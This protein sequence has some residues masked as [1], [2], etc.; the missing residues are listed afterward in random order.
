MVQT[1]FN[2]KFKINIKRHKLKIWRLKKKKK[3]LATILIPERELAAEEWRNTLTVSVSEWK[4]PLLISDRT[5]ELESG[6]AR[7]DSLGHQMDDPKTTAGT[8]CDVR[9]PSWLPTFCRA[10]VVRERW[11]G[12]ASKEDTFFNPPSLLFVGQFDVPFHGMLFF[13]TYLSDCDVQL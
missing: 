12:L 1:P 11:G 4:D 9:R 7:K 5:S 8:G 13:V 10:G 3:N 6:E 2:Y